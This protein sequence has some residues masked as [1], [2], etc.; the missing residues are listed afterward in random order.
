VR[1][2]RDQHPSPVGRLVLD[3]GH[4]N[5]VVLAYV[6][7]FEAGDAQAVADL[8]A[9]DARLEDPAGAPAIQGREAILAFYSR[10]MDLGAKLC[11]ADPVRLAAGHAAFA[12][13]V[14]TAGPPP[15]H[16]DVIDVFTFDDQGAIAAMIAYW[17]PGNVHAAP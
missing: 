2:G 6:Q 14:T 9:P 13:R 4:M 10:A 11:L 5:R 3:P 17:G 16:I 8:F 15:V 1:P 7:A 12:F